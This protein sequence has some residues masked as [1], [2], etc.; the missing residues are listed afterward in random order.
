[1]RDGEAGAATSDLRA[2]D[3]SLRSAVSRA[4]G[5]D[6]EGDGRLERLNAPELLNADRERLGMRL[7]ARSAAHE[8]VEAALQQRHQSGVPIAK[9]E[10]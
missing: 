10:Q 6:E 3:Q 4:A 7:G 5:E 8:R 1:M 9:D 2:L